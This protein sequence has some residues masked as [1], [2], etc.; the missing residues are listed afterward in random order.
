MSLL[1]RLD[2]EDKIIGSL[3]HNKIEEITY[4]A[5]IPFL[6]MHDKMD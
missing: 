2:K 6:V 3:F 1:S 5:R 4:H